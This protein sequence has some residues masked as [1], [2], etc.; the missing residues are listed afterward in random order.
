MNF[1]YFSVLPPPPPKNALWDSVRLLKEAVINF[2]I[3]G[4]MIN[5]QSIIFVYSC[6]ICLVNYRAYLVPWGGSVVEGALCLGP[7]CKGMELVT[8]L[9]CDFGVQLLAWFSH[10]RNGCCCFLRN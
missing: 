7:G 6:S 8:S 5:Y 9:L 3:I 10:C 4:K 1:T 2:S